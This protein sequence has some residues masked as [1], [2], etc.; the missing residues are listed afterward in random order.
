MSYV[1]A[2]DQEGNL[3]LLGAEVT[4][5]PWRE[6]VLYWMKPEATAKAWSFN[7]AKRIHVSPFFPV[8]LRYRWSFTPPDETLL[9]RMALHQGAEL[10]FDVDLRLARQPWTP[11]AIRHSLLRFPFHTMKV[12]T[13][14]HWEALRLWLKRVPIHTHP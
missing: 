2:F 13:A 6:R 1:Y 5:T 9:V 14:I 7:A 12:I 8:D 4:N 10:V 11:R 3:A